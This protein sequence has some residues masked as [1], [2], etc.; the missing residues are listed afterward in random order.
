MWCSRTFVLFFGLVLVQA[1][2]TRRSKMIDN[3]L[4]YCLWYTLHLVFCFFACFCLWG[5]RCDFFGDGLDKYY[6]ICWY[7][8][9]THSH[10]IVS[11][12]VNTC[13]VLWPN[14][15]H[16][17][18]HTCFTVCTSLKFAPV[19]TDRCSVQETLGEPISN[20]LV[21]VNS[22]CFSTDFSDDWRSRNSSLLAFFSIV[23]L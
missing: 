7:C 15:F 22:Q 10:I 5:C 1:E 20:L 3:M 8:G 9:V 23:G 2:K 19:W 4:V 14:I 11:I 21:V 6:T 12:S 13:M 18:K 17:K 16:F